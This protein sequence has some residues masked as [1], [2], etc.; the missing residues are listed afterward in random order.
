MCGRAW[1]GYSDDRPRLSPP[2]FV[3]PA[4]MF[5]LFSLRAL[6]GLALA[7]LVGLPALDL[8]EASAQ[9]K[10]APYDPTK[11]PAPAAKG[12][13]APGKKLTAAELA[14]HIDKAIDDKLKAEKVEP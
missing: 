3:E 6:G 13:L 8:S 10:K 5:K 12:T 11:K 7:A 2:R 1:S 4:A 9:K 14:R